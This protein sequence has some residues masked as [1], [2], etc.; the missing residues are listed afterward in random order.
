MK[1][2]DKKIAKNIWR[3]N[4]EIART[5][6]MMISHAVDEF[7]KY[8]KI[9]TGS[10]DITEYIGIFENGNN[11]GSY[12]KV[13]QLRAL[14]D[15]TFAIFINTPEKIEKIHK[16]TLEYNRNLY[17]NLK[18]YEDI[19]FENQ[20]REDL[21]SIFD[22]IIEQMKSAHGYAV[23]TTWFV[24]SD[25]EDLSNY[26]TSEIKNKAEEQ[27][28]K[29]SIPEAFSILTTPSKSSLGQ[30]EE[31]EFY[32][33]L[34]L[35][36]KDNLAKNIFN[37][38]NA[39][40]IESELDKINEKIKNKIV[41]HF[42]NW[43]WMPYTYIGP[44]YELK[45]YIN[46]W[47]QMVRQNING[48]EEIDKIE[49]AH[50]EVIEKRNELINTF[51]FTEKEKKIFDLAAD[52]VWLKGYRK[53]VSFF[54]YFVLGK[55]MKEL[56]KRASLSTNQINQL[57]F[58][59]FKDFDKIDPNLL[60]KRFKFSVMHFHNGNFS[61]YTGEDARDFIEK[62]KFEK[63][64][65]IDSDELTGTPAFIGKVNGIVKVINYPE[66]MGKMENENIMIAH[67]T[68]PS[69][70]PAMKKAAAIITDDGGITCHA[71]IVARELKKPCIV[72]TKRATQ[73]LKDGDEIEVD[74]DNGIIRILK[75]A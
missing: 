20:S 42:K 47:S 13:N 74:A 52:V 5:H 54:G 3:K 26:L 55:I 16:K 35:I 57:M 28:L 22:K 15:K 46:L 50:K 73:V 18:K 65:N 53:E 41:N 32:E 60:N 58:F 48:Q 59:E 30:E 67:T 37:Y 25:G 11:V 14:V 10:N 36:S 62:Q 40:K 6:Y 7:K 17:K 4:F 21:I 31:K 44:A 29:I 39:E 23:T 63:I 68:F 61:V 66:E 72:G 64:K 34:A 71:A 56:A 9:T 33:I 70:I 2:N 51:K 1:N 24:D 12:F 19:D 49:R 8:P 45:Y 69:L 43:K 27:K 38:E 75:R